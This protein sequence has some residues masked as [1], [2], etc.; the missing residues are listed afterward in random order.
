MIAL[1]TLI[2]E[3]YPPKY[4]RDDI[5]EIDIYPDGELVVVRNRKAEPS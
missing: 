1:T 3:G 4:A 5:H 2:C